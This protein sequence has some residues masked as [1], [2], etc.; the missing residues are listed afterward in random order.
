MSDEVRDHWVRAE[1]SFRSARQLVEDDPDSAASRAYYAAFHAVCALLLSR[2]SSFAKH[3]AVETAVHRDLVRPG[4]WSAELGAAY[5]W[6]VHVRLTG[7]YGGDQ[8]VTVDEA[9]TAVEKARMIIEAA[10]TADRGGE[11]PGNDTAAPDL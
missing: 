8:H 1:N 5:S 7:D 11:L 6:L 10:R 3:A 4:E 2:G 9:R